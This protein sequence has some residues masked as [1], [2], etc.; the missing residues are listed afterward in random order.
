[1]NFDINKYLTPEN[2]NFTSYESNSYNDDFSKTLNLRNSYTGEDLNLS[3][4]TTYTSSNNDEYSKDTFPIENSDSSNYN[5][6]NI[7][8]KK[9]STNRKDKF[10][11]GN[12][13]NKENHFEI[14]Y[15]NKLDTNNNVNDFGGLSNNDTLNKFYEL[16]IKDYPERY[17]LKSNSFKS[18]DNNSKKYNFFSNLF[19]SFI[20]K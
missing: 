15:N 1:M 19:K 3:R 16:D 18:N 14:E 8:I 5:I 10:D 13:S 2:N 12:L 20:K 4:E 7:N 17:D 11:F 6:E 9:Y